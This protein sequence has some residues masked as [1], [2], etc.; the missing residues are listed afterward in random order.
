[1]ADEFEAILRN[2][3][4]NPKAIHI[5]FEGKVPKINGQRMK[6]SKRARTLNCLARSVLGITRATRH[7]MKRWSQVIGRPDWSATMNVAL[8]LQKRGFLCY[9]KEDVEADCQIAQWAAQQTAAVSTIVVGTD[10]DFLAFAPGVI[11]LISPLSSQGYLVLKKDVLKCMGLTEEQFCLFFAINGC[12]NV[13]SFRVRRDNALSF[14][15]TLKERSQFK[16]LDWSLLDLDNVEEKELSKQV[17]AIW[18]SYGWSAT[19]KVTTMLRSAIE[20]ATKS[21]LLFHLN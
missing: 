15:K 21:K 18:N 7:K 20:S 6:E 10:A 17:R 3:H 2:I 14:V 12:D 16:R 1:M 9:G 13:R 11:A 8:I 4:R 19:I 5:F